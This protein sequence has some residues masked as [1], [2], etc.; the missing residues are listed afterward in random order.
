L[1]LSFGEVEDLGKK[2]VILFILTFALILFLFPQEFALSQNYPEGIMEKQEKAR[3][4]EREIADL[5]RQLTM[6]HDE[7]LIISRR[8]DDIEE[9]IL[10]CYLEIDRVQAEIQKI[11]KN[12]NLM[13]R[14][15]Y[16]EGQLDDVIKI[17]SAG[18]VVDFVGKFDN[19]LRV[20][21]KQAVPLKAM[22]KKRNELMN[23]RE[24]LYGYKREQLRLA[25]SVNT[26][27]IEA[28]LSEKKAQLAYLTGEIIAMQLPTTTTPLPSNFDPARTY[29]KPDENAFIRTGEVFSGYASW[30]GNEFHG[31][32]TASGE[33]F[34]QY[35][36]TCA[37][38]SLPFG[39][40]L[41]VVFKGRSVIVKVNDRGPFVKG[42]I[43]DLSRG[44]A[45]AIGLTGVQWVDCEIVI[46]RGS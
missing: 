18:D 39:T 21:T 17:F 12:F 19:L 25:E 30:Y 29:I 26:Q 35:A 31:R 28:N 33:I 10:D 23:V 3:V 4:L 42:R 22:R 44:A 1:N 13:I 34:D 41:R 38:R 16:V 46:P 36:F 20:A 37:H 14:Q 9:K 2:I 32:P 8:L 15:I 45:E 6:A 43:L 5:E 40:W 7:W 27:S 11:R 24:E